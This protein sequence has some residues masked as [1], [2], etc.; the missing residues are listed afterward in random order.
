[1]VVLE[2]AAQVLLKEHFHGEA[3]SRALVEMRCSFWV[4]MTRAACDGLGGINFVK[5]WSHWRVLVDEL[6]NELPAGKSEL[7]DRAMVRF[8]VH[9]V[10]I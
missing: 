7:L 3:S 4:G 1:V 10:E 5:N 2:E 6:R 8:P 9:G